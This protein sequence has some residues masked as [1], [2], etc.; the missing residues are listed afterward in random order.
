MATLL[1]VCGGGLS[2]DR[3]TGGSLGGWEG[4]QVALPEGLV[5]GVIQGVDQC[6][7]LINHSV[8]GDLGHRVL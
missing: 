7:I 1:S 4:I 3:D 6:H 2:H 8:A 5:L